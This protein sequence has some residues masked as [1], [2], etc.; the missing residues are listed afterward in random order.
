VVRILG[1]VNVT[2]DSFSDGGKYETGQAAIAHGRRLV[3]E[4]AD[5][6]D[7]GGES[8]RPGATPVSME[9]ER[10]RVVEVIAALRSERPVSIDTYK[11]QVADAALDAGATIVNDVSGGLLDPAILGVV[12]AR[13]ATVILGHLRGTP[14]TM[15]EHARYGDV[16]AEV[17]DE[18]RARIAAA[19]TSGIAADRIWIDPGL[20]FAKRA[21]HSIAILSRLDALRVLGCPIVV[22]ASRKS[23]L[24][25]LDGAGVDAREEA[26]A[27]A[28]AIAIDRGAEVVRVH[29]VARQRAAVRVAE[30]L[31][32]ARR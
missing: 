27:A 30:A 13:G 15:M 5:L 26:T 16:V 2:P 22:G 19:R 20:G 32:Q 24:D 8:T 14:A 7:V 3:A 21:E 28:H 1:V 18:L 12:A 17:I 9:E 29:D 31:R 6:I 11:A 4:G 25:A 10:G 23:F